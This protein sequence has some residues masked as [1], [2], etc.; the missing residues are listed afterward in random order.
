MSKRIC[1][2]RKTCI[3]VYNGASFFSN[4]VQHFK[5]ININ[6]NKKFVHCNKHFF[7]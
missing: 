1:M 4:S 7:F 5:K 3:I 6:N 2:S